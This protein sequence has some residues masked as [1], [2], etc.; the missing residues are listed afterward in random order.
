MSDI[1]RV[2]Y[3]HLMPHMHKISKA[4]ADVTAGIATHAEKEHVKRAERLKDLAI[5]NQLERPVKH[6]VTPV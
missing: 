6:H 3:H 4:S 2:S 5:R 1:P